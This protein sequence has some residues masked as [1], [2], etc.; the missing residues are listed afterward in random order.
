MRITKKETVRTVSYRLRGDG[1]AGKAI[2]K[3]LQRPPRQLTAFDR[4]EY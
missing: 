3:R 4:I 1:E 2:E